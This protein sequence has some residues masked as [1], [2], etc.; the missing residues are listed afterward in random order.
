MIYR[1]YLVM[2]KALAWYAALVLVLQVVDLAFPP[3]AAH[4]VPY[5]DVAMTAGV[6][7][8]LFAWIFAVALGNGSRA[9]ARVLWVLPTERWKAALQLIAV[10]FAGIVLAFVWFFVTD[11][12]MLLIPGEKAHLV[13]SAPL[14]E[15]ALS[16][17][18]IFAIYGWG[19]LVGMLGRRMAYCGIIATPALAIWL[20]VAEHHFAI[21]P[22]FRATSLAN[23]F[24]VI[25]ARIAL[26]SWQQD[27]YPIDLVTKSL[28][29]LG[30]SWETPVLCAIGAATCGLAIFLW[31]RARVI[32]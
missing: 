13:G 26:V 1:E 28:L 17:A 12:A 32:Y 29:W 11:A 5:A 16:L 22:V 18:G 24:A 30:T 10:D 20:T 31:Q 9:A 21:S 2:R 3:K 4:D 7:A 6:F 19:A 25:N 8:A 15:I 27:H 23:P 14:A